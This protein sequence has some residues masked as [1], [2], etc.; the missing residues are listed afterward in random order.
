[1]AKVVEPQVLTSRILAFMLSASTGVL[2][3]LVVTLF[4]MIPLERPEIFFVSASSSLSNV[5]I[6][7][8]EPDAAMLKSYEE[9]F[10]REYIIARNTL[11]KNA[12][13]TR[14]NWTKIVKPWSSD[15]VYSVMT[16]TELYRAYIQDNLSQMLECGVNFKGDV[17]QPRGSKSRKEWIAEFDWVCK[18][19]SGQSITKN[20]TIVIRLKSNLDEK[21]SGTAENLSKLR[22]N[23]LGTQVVSYEV[24][25][26][27]TH[28]SGGEDPLN[29]TGLDM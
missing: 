23:P 18:N 12:E 28:T 16:K 21:L 14:R 20:Y 11:Y 29:S 6:K 24:L 19:N 1:M 10:V 9:G 7:G 4:K 25:D 27:V 13:E 22:V 5:S 2:A 17:S 3:V 15:N 26:S 8:M